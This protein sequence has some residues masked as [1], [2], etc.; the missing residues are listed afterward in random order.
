[1]TTIII[2]CFNQREYLNEAVLSTLAQRDVDVIVV[3]DG[4]TD[5]S[6]DL[7]SRYP[8]VRVIRQANGGVAA[9]RNTGLHA[10]SDDFILFLDADDRL[11]GGAVERLRAAL[12]AQPNA[13]LAYGR[14]TLIDAEGKPLAGTSPPHAPGTA[15]EAL[16]RSNFI[17]VPGAVL[18][19]RHLLLT[20]GG[21][22][23]GIDPAAD[24]ELYLR[25]A[26]RH[27]IVAVD[28]VVVEYRRHGASMSADP[29]RTLAATLQAH[30]WHGRHVHGESVRDAYRAGRRFWGEFYGD[31]LMDRA[32]LAW[33]RRA[34][35]EAVLELLWVAR[36]APR[37]LLAHAGRLARLRLTRQS[38]RSV[39]KTKRLS[40]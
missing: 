3:D 25:L 5:G 38:Q 26:R 7:A 37:V 2:P 1:M 14:H 15:F 29:G 6:G 24:Y 19:R 28:D 39:Y 12:E 18:H 13:A 16:L 9:A 32:R 23:A 31:Q 10:A 17:T 21:F 20:A 30:R 8:H 34:L 11:T 4:S 22:A 33:R 27:P 36:L 40:S 35:R